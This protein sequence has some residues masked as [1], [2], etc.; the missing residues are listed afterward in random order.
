MFRKKNDEANKKMEE[1]VKLP[2]S[3]K[4]N[5]S[6]LASSLDFLRR[7]V[8]ARLEHHF[9]KTSRFEQPSFT[10]TD[11]GSVFSQFISTRKMIMEEFLTLLLALSPHSHPDL[12]SDLIKL[13]LPKGG[14]FPEF[15]GVK[16][17]N[18]RGIIPTGETALFVLAG[19]NIDRRL[20][21]GSLLKGE[22]LANDR[23]NGDGKIKVL[24]IFQ[25]G[26]VILEPVRDGEPEMSG[27]LMLAPEKIP[28]FLTGD[29]WRP[30]FGLNFPASRLES[31]MNWEDV[32]LSPSTQRELNM[33]KSWLE[34]H[35]TVDADPN[36]GRRIKPGYRALFHGPPGTGKTLTATLLGK[37]FG[38]DVFR[39]DLSM[40]VSKYIGETEKNLQHVFDTA[41]NKNCILFFDEADALFGKR[42]NVQSAHDRFANQEISYLLQKVEEHPGLIILASNF[43]SNM[44]QA[45]IRRFQVVVHFNVPNE[46]ERLQLWQNMLPETIDVS[47]KIN[48]PELARNYELSGAS[49]LNILHGASI[50]ALSENRPVQETDLIEGVQNEYTKSGKSI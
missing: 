22:D 38:L 35:F 46:Q 11:D 29:P 28:E 36:L 31:R 41:A 47:E 21:C 5:N 32:V 17:T 3:G 2:P 40:I 15:G 33:I 19:M 8:E 43:K 13:Y 14:D 6:V 24:N 50:R 39:I 45:F 9:G 49:I 7:V 27:R 1:P 26:I 42:T 44:D 37:Q 20:K 34:N 4:S 12:F 16:G 48:F 23:T 25:E 30:R 10:I 18:Y